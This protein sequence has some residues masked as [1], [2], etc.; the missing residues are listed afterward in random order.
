MLFFNK[1]SVQ[2]KKYMSQI[3]TKFR[4]KKE[5]S[6]SEKLFEQVFYQILEAISIACPMKRPKTMKEKI[7]KILRDRFLKW[8][9]LGGVGLMTS[10]M[11]IANM[12]SL[13]K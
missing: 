1:T 5:S 11:I 3:L 9:L 2:L 12:V 13:R 7:L 4:V 6:G 10:G 8:G